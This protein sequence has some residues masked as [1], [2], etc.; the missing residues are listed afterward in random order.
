[1]QMCELLSIPLS[2]YAKPKMYTQTHR[3]GITR[4]HFLIQVC[5]DMQGQVKPQISHRA[6]PW[7]V[8]KHADM[9]WLSSGTVAPP[10]HHTLT[11]RCNDVC[12]CLASTVTFL[13]WCAK[14]FTWIKACRGLPTARTK[15]QMHGCVTQC[16]ISEQITLLTLADILCVILC[17]VLYIKIAEE[18]C[19]L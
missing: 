4:K 9:R 18:V 16:T 17:V 19:L 10:Q 8:Y 14:G 11:V 7:K 6:G 5:T 12:V 2:G 1:M 13:Q 15:Q 3:Y